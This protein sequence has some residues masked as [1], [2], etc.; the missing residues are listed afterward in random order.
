MSGKGRTHKI[1]DEIIEKCENALK[2]K[3]A[4]EI[5]KCV[6]EHYLRERQ[7]REANNESSL[8]YCSNEQL[9]H[10]LAD[11]FGA[12]VDTTLTT[13]RWFLL[14][15]A[16]YPG[17]QNRLR[18]EM[19]TNLSSAPTLDDYNKL[20]YMRAAISETQRIR[21]VVPLGIPHGA[22]AVSIPY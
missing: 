14:Y 8:E 19:K 4:N 20:T 15:I 13:L 22:I 21:S 5:P 16:K 10:L 9:R 12:G 3:N 1:Y 17:I 6:L 18:D 11:L 7:K 2:T